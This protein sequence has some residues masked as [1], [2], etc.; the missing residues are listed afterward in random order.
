M[1]LRPHTRTAIR[2]SVMHRTLALVCMHALV[3]QVGAQT[4]LVDPFM[5]LD[6]TKMHHVYELVDLGVCGTYSGGVQTKAELE[7]IRKAE[8]EKERRRLEALR[9]E[10]GLGPYLVALAE[11]SRVD[12]MSCGV[13]PAVL[14]AMTLRQD[15]EPEVIQYYI[16]HARG[17]IENPP[18]KLADADHELL[19][20]IP[21][22][23]VAQVKPESEALLV[24][25]LE[26]GESRND[27]RM[28]AQAG[29]ALGQ[30]GTAQSVPSMVE[31]VRW[32]QRHSADGT[33]V[34]REQWMQ[35]HLD[36]LRAR[37]AHKSLG[38]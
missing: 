7:R 34:G 31:A 21:Y 27:Y 17:L 37:V 36:K 16:E 15:V 29:R 35:G 1:S 30:S 6:R 18:A 4:T 20:G 24:K 25:L 32:V 22:L 12:K 5:E 10:P 33:E 13:L 28:V 14:E 2:F 26:L 3:V 38:P 23:L 9:T 11:K 8:E 19:I